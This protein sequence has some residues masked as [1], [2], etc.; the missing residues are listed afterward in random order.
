M[1]AICLALV[2]A[3]C[4][5][6]ES[7]SEPGATSGTT[8][9]ELTLD[10]DGPDG[11]MPPQTQTASCEAGAGESPCSAV[12]MADFAPV[13]PDVACTELYGG[14]DA[15]SVDGT[16]AGEAVA[17]EFTRADGCQ[18]ERFDR[19]LPLLRELFPDYRPGASLGA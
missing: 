10:A 3:G 19:F 12:T 2:L 18:I 8:E 1:I 5:D 16:V 17:S 15:L 11:K 13:A 14:P 7:G 6:D 4:G 9:L